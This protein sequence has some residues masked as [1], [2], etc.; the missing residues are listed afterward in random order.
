MNST[1]S[2]IYDQLIIQKANTI[3]S[4]QQQQQQQQNEKEKEDDEKMIDRDH[5]RNC[6]YDHLSVGAIRYAVP[7]GRFPEHID[8]CGNNSWV[9]LLSLGCTANFVVKGPSMNKKKEFGFH[10][11]DIK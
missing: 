2:S 10:S 3:L 1:T 7:N 6:K 11:G 8:H 9:Y 5:N 4:Q